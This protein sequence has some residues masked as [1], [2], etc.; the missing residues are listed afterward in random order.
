MR[1][2]INMVTWSH[3]P[4]IVKVKKTGFVLFVLLTI[5]WPS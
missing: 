2:R 5:T 1:V 3:H 4:E